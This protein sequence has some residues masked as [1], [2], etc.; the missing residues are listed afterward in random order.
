MTIEEV[1]RQIAEIDAE[2]I[3]LI[4]RRV[5]L[6]DEV[7]RHKHQNGLPINDEKHNSVVLERAAE[8]AT[9]NNLDIAPVKQI[10]DILIRMNIERQRELSG[11]GNLP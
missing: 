3:G 2:L 6:A 4:S 9:E 7:L 5:S 8:A 10:F 1:R 11:E